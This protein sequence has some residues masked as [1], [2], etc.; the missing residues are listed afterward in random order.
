MVYGKNYELKVLK[1]FELR[2]SCKI[3][4]VGL[5]ILRFKLFLGVILDVL[6][7]DDCFVEVKCL[8]LGRN[9]K[10]FFGKYFRFLD[11]NEKNEIILKRISNYYY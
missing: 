10:I 5:C 7:Y 6:L 2:Y 8:Y 1:L 9:E 11:Y 3:R 4:L